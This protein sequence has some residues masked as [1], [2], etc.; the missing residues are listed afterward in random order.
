MTGRT[1]ELTD[2]EHELLISM[3]SKEF[4]SKYLREKESQILAFR[5]HDYRFIYKERIGIILWWDFVDFAFI[6]YIVVKAAFR[7]QGN[8]SNLLNKIKSSNRLIILEVED[9]D[10]RLKRFYRNNGFLE[11]TIPYEAIQINETPQD[12]LLLMSYDHELS[13]EEYDMFMNTISADDLQ[14]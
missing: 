5:H 10:E 6:E 4:E 7:N 2:T 14:F 11:C 9:T 13:R 8:G 1:A 3:L 12:N